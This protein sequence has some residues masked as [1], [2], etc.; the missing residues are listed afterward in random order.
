MPDVRALCLKITDLT[1]T[2]SSTLLTTSMHAGILV[3]TTKL[4]STLLYCGNVSWDHSLV[5]VCGVSG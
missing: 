1:G 5:S 2:V 4:V 3:Y